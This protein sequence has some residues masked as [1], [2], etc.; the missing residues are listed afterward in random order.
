[1]TTRLG[2]FG[3]DYQL[4]SKFET[5]L[6]QDSSVEVVASSN[7][8]DA[9][10][11]AG[12]FDLFFDLSENA[13]SIK[14]NAQSA[15][16]VGINYINVS[17]SL[18]DVDIMEF[19]RLSELFPSRCVI[20]LSDLSLAN[21][22][23]LGFAKKASTFFSH[24][25]LLSSGLST[26]ESKEVPDARNINFPKGIKTVKTLG[27]QGLSRNSLFLA[28][29]GER[30]IVTAEVSAIEQSIGGVRLAIQKSIRLTGMYVGLESLI[31][32]I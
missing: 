3:Q 13:K 23:L 29:D 25:E 26:I 21:A 20:L 31:D 16:S 28:Q 27:M 17:T 14:T 19:K 30:L 9:D 22:L 24:A 2:L 6:L 7:K 11:M 15:L 8:I 10:L 1:M 4:L 18:D 5:I 12:S 32:T